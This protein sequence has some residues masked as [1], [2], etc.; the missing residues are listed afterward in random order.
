VGRSCSAGGRQGG[1]RRRA[2]CTSISRS[3]RGVRFPTRV[4]PVAALSI[5]AGT[6]SRRQGASRHALCGAFLKLSV[7][8]CVGHLQI[9]Q[10]NYTADLL[11]WVD[12]ENLPA[13]LGGRSKVRRGQQNR[14]RPGGCARSA[15]GPWV[16]RP[17]AAGACAKGRLVSARKLCLCCP[18]MCTLPLF[19]TRTCARAHAHTRTHAHMLAHMRMHIHAHARA[20]TRA[21]THIH[22]HTKTHPLGIPRQLKGTLLD[23]VGPW[24]D[25]EVLHRL[26]A[27]LPAA[28]RA[29]RALRHSAAT[30]LAEEGEEDGYQSPRCVCVCVCVRGEGVAGQVKHRARWPASGRGR[31]RCPAVALCAVIAKLRFGAVLRTYVS[32]PGTRHTP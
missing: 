7:D 15:I 2:A 32:V 19:P 20:H 31:M 27:D 30:N 1:T 9:C 11:E 3:C 24:S 28:G 10:T 25:P 18:C 22:A 4:R 16:G 8:A 21:H 13:W 23:D 14:P 26:E 12:P 17:G 29:L 5:W 6:E